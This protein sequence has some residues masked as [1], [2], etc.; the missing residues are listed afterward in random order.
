MEDNDASEMSAVCGDQ[1]SSCHIAQLQDNPPAA[2]KYP[3]PV[4]AIAAGTDK[5]TISVRL[6]QVIQPQS[7]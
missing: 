7:S 3:I 1:V 6:C 5:A 2:K 4:I